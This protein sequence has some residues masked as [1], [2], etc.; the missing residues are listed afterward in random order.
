MTFFNLILAPTNPSYSRFHP[1]FLVLSHFLL[2]F[3]CEG[4][5]SPS[6]SKW[7][8]T[9]WFVLKFSSLKVPHDQPILPNLLQVHQH[10]RTVSSL[11]PGK[12]WGRNILF[13]LSLFKRSEKWT[14]NV[15]FEGRWYW[16]NVSV[17]SEIWEGNYC[18]VVR[19]ANWGFVTE[20]E[21]AKWFCYDDRRSRNR[22][23]HF[24][25]WISFWLMDVDR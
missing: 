16:T 1:F 17:L 24:S 9:P 14:K 23:V 22:C 21:K 13:S 3:L 10:L 8:D 2:I 11:E 4:P 5:T 6:Y 25:W 19:P 18:L 20:E 7:L 15:A 12:K